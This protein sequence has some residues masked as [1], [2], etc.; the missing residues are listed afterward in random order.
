LIV[1]LNNGDER[2]LDTQSAFGIFPITGLDTTENK[3]VENGRKIAQ[4]LCVPFIEGPI[5]R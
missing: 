1:E 5:R 2:V 3:Q 4:F